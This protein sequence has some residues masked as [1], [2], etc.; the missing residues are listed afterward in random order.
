MLSSCRSRYARRSLPR[1]TASWWRRTATTASSWSAVR[2]PTWCCSTSAC[3]IA[4]ASRC[5]RSIRAIDARIPVIFIATAK[6]ADA[7]IEA[8]KHGAFDYLHKPLDLEQLQR[9]VTDALEVARMRL[10]VRLADAAR[11]GRRRDA[12]RLAADARHLQGDRPGRGPGR[13]G[14]DH[15]R[16]RHR[17]G[18]GRAGDLPAQLALDRAVPRAQLRR[19][20][21]RTCSRA[22]CSVTSAAR[23]PAPIAGGSASSSSATAAPCCSTRSATCRSPCRPRS[24][25]CYRIRRSSGS[26]ATRRSAPTSG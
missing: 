8:M 13:H 21:R 4:T 15:R 19:D 10:P 1:R 18:A 24:C 11:R 7:A 16:E 22:S 17:Q 6:T 20:P 23:S 25:A 12:R 14:A 3:R 26:A 2:R 9:V 5:Y